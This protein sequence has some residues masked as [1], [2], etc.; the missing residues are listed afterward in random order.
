[1]QAGYIRNNPSSSYRQTRQ[2]QEGNMDATRTSIHTFAFG[3]SSIVDVF[4]VAFVISHYECNSGRSTCRQCW[5]P[6]HESKMIG[7]MKRRGGDERRFCDSNELETTQFPYRSIACHGCQELDCRKRF[8]TQERVGFC[9]WRH[10]F[11]F[12]RYLT[13]KYSKIFLFY[14]MATF[15]SFFPTVRLCRIPSV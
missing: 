2:D 10:F 4:L 8:A 15:F 13:K 12:V 3:C 9:A 1:M 6:Y 11:F 5:V 14:M 7:G